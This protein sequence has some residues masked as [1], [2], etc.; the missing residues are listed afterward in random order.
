[1]SPKFLD[2]QKKLMK[3]T[4]KLILVA[5]QIKRG[6]DY[7]CDFIDVFKEYFKSDVD[8]FLIRMILLNVYKHKC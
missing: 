5:R 3:L 1:M 6:D 8:S 2:L 7:E 4:A